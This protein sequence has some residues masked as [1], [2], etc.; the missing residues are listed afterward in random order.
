MTISY[1]CFLQAVRINTMKASAYSFFMV[2]GLEKKCSEIGGLGQRK[3]FA[4]FRAIQV[5]I[6]S[7][8]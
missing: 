2:E 5:S 4:N 8:K 7:L 6:H 1:S 3:V